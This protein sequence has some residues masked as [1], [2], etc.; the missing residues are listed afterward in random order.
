IRTAINGFSPPGLIKP[1]MLRRAREIG[2]T[3]GYDSFVIEAVE[4]H[5]DVPGGGYLVQSRVRFS[6]QQLSPVA[7]LTYAVNGADLYRSSLDSSEAQRFAK[8]KGSW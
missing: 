3:R 6:A 5:Y 4:L 2:K 7:G 8:L 1:L